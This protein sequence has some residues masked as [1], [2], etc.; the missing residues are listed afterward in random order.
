MRHSRP[1][2]D[3]EPLGPLGGPELHLR[4]RG[5]FEGRDILW[6]ARFVSRRHCGATANA[7]DIGEDGPAGRTLTVVLD[8]HCFDAPTVRKAIIM[9]RQYKRLRPGRHDF[10]RT[11]S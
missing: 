1:P 10:G 4:F 8:V 6:D 11:P 3:F 2:P 7:V 9:V 5:P